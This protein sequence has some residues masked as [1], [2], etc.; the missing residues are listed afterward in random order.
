MTNDLFGYGFR[1]RKAVRATLILI[2]LLGIQYLLMLVRPAEGTQ[3]YL[4]YKSVVAFL[5]SFQVQN[6]GVIFD[7]VESTPA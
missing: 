3:G 6:C 2:P 7:R 4:V 1:S 5:S